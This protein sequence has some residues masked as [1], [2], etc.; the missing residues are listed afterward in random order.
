MAETYAEFMERIYEMPRAEA[1]EALYYA[2]TG[3]KLD[4]AK[5]R[6]LNEK[7]QWLMVNRYDENVSLFA[8]KLAVRDYVRACGYED[9][10]TQLYGAYVSAE[11]AYRDIT[12][13]TSKDRQSRGG[14]DLLPD[15]YVLKC[16]HGSGPK[17]IS[18]CKDP[19]SFDLKA[20]TEK[21]GQ[22]L[23]YDYSRVGL[24]HH[25]HYIHPLIIAE[26]YLGDSPVD[27]K[28]FCFSGKAKYVKVIAGRG[29]GVH[30][31]Y[32]DMDRNFCPFVKDEISIQ[33][34]DYAFAE[35]SALCDKKVFDRMAE[36]ASKLSEPFPVAR[37]DLYYENGRIY[38]GEI[39]LTPATG[40][41]RTDKPETLELLGGLVDL[42]YWKPERLCF[43]RSDE[44]EKL[45]VH[46]DGTSGAESCAPDVAKQLQSVA[47]RILADPKILLETDRATANGL[48]SDSARIINSDMQK[49]LRE[50]Y[51]S[52]LNMLAYRED[53]SLEEC[54]QIFW[55][56]N[57][58]MFLDYSLK[59]QGV[60]IEEL[61]KYIVTFIESMLDYSFAGSDG[62]AD[63][64]A[65]ADDNLRGR[66]GADSGSGVVVLTTYQFLTNGHAPTQRLLDYAYALQHDLGRHVVIINDAGMHFYESETLAG[67]YLF[68]FLD[69]LNDSDHID[70]KD[71]RFEFF[72]V[73]VRMPDISVLQ[74]LVQMVWSLKPE[75]VLS[76]GGASLLADLC[77]PFAVTAAIPCS[78]LFPI[79]A[80]EYMLLPRK[81]EA[82]DRAHVEALGV[83]VYSESEPADRTVQKLVET[84]YNFVIRQSEARYSRE[85][86]EVPG[87]AVAMC[88]VGN[89][90]DAEID[91]SYLRILSE[92]YRRAS[93]GEI[94]APYM[95][96]IGMLNDRER[97]LS[98]L[99]KDSHRYLRFT[100]PVKDAGELVRH[101]DIYLNPDRSG[102][103]RSVFEAC[104]Y[105]VVPV[106]FRRGDGFYAAGPKF[107]VSDE[108][109]YA[110]RVMKLIERG[111]SFDIA[112]EH[113]LARGASLSDMTGTMREILRVCR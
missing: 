35:S 75:L 84:N 5:P 42:E 62:E 108:A 40:L 55:N 45:T 24:E 94:S 78:T 98:A 61:Y 113:A 37:V 21:L 104:Y 95:L 67:G 11:D 60:D 18:I 31:D 77:R 10:L 97:V 111:P 19:E 99:P 86:Y 88:V 28:F 96:F 1:H 27:Y 63:R 64:G 48:M 36:T 3:K 68:N 74:Q 112:R 50:S 49:R 89:R 25:Y 91:G 46:F 51:M 43:T 81:L 100:G 33:A 12:A 93:A 30:Q 52:I 53:M 103:G 8:D 4:L 16:T 29:D 56:L 54:W 110:E 70:Y 105:G 57:R 82:E 107:G 39:T 65:G 23:S 14:N 20:E 83:H 13:R 90:L 32:Y 17:F 22:S 101:A 73:P 2:A 76:V 34:N 109:E 85:Q 41:N 9:I 7:L 80:S 71:E 15:R 102:G 106:S 66:A 59:P 44:E 69:K 72:Q 79:T 92:I 38:F 26:E 47:D 87:D 6:N 58:A